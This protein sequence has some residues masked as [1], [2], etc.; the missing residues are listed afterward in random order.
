MVKKA[1]ILTINDD[2]NL[3][4]RLQ[5]YAVQESLRKYNIKVETISNQDGIYGIRYLKKKVVNTLKKIF[6]N[7]EETFR[8]NNFMKFNKNIK[9][10]KYR[11]DQ[12]HIPS[13]INKYYDC[14]FTGSDQ[15]WNPNFKSRSDI[16]FLTFA[17]KEKRNSISAS[18][19]VNNIPESQR[20]RYKK[21]L[22]EMKNISVREERGKEIIKEITNRDDVE[23]LVDPT[24]LLEKEEWEKVMVKPQKRVPQ[25]YILNYFLGNLSEE[26]EKKIK[27]FAK[28]N[29]C[30]IINIL[31]KKDPFY[32]YGPSEFIFLEKNAFAICT[33]SFHSCVFAIL[34]KRPFI[35]FERDDLYEKMNSRIE[36]L[37]K[38]FELKNRILEG[39]IDAE[40]L[41]IDY[42][43]VDKIL[44]KE[45]KKA[46]NYIEKVLNG[47]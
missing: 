30:Q 35:V 18:F 27:E 3:G 4:N 6:P 5:N 36:T 41:E 28:K 10:S 2:M 7:K 22:E 21:N 25:K 46:S 29:E 23:V 45:R 12:K 39:N 1:A 37:L 19:G 8:Y 24:M 17:S 40:K 13:K 20:K 38:K 43:K 16:D 44:K 14:F 33:D 11:I 15:V 9:Y 47:N 26:R 34:F 31:D 42:S 32:I